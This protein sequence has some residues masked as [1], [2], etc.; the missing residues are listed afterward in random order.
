MHKFDSIRPFYD[1]EVNKAIQSIIND[2]MLEAMMKFTFPEDENM[3]WKLL[4]LHTHS[5]RD[6]QINFIYPGLKKVLEK[7]S[8]GLTFSGFEKL[9]PNTA[10]LFISNH[11]DIVLDTS[12]L[13]SCL[14]ENGLVMTTSAI[15]DNLVKRP[16][17]NTLSRLNRNFVIERGAQGRKLLE[18]SN[19]V[20]SYIHN[21]ILHENRSVWTAQ[22]EGRSKDGNDLTHKGVLKMLTLAHEGQNPF[23]SFK[24]LKLVPVSISYE[25]DPTDILKL[26]ELIAKSLGEKYIKS[27]NEDF[28]NLLRGIIGTKKHIHIHVHGTIEDDLDQ[29]NQEDGNLSEKLTLLTEVIDRYILQGYKLWPSKYIACDLLNNSDRYSDQYT[30]EEKQ[31]F[32]TRFEEKVKTDDPVTRQNFLSM[33]A[34]P[35]VNKEKLS[36]S[37]E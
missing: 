36:A 3:T 19:L 34:N 1:S 20:S 25:Y 7:S 10:Y 11:R 26:P 32:M 6:F 35:V 4:M 23:D 2:P 18:N 27:E 9:E 28:L 29:I 8:E 12:L 21:A 5:L 31:A 33:Y 22:R 15:G 24:E 13:N 16:F 14:Y 17:L 37:Q 30:A